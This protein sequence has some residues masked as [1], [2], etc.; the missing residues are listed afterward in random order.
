MYVSSGPLAAIAHMSGGP[1]APWLS[2]TVKFYPA[3][4]GVLVVADIF[5][6]PQDN[7]SGFFAFHIHE[8]TDCSGDGF[9][10]TGGHYNPAAVPHPRHAGDLPPL[11][12][13][14]DRA[15][16]A[17]W[18][19]RFQVQEVI[20]HTAVIHSGP[21]DFVSQPAGNSGTKIACGVIHSA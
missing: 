11:L 18:T 1:L 14:R 16:Q 13:V 7:P 21:D 10:D 2:G 4:S 3:K 5:G 19:D 15:F 12:R 6:L 17:V 20:G 9:A 8:G